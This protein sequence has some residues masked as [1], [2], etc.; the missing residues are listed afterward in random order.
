MRAVRVDGYR[1]AGRRAAKLVAELVG[2]SPAAR[3][4]VPPLQLG[5]GALSVNLKQLGVEVSAAAVSRARQV[6]R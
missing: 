4:P 3:V 1:E 6:Y 2:R 5:P